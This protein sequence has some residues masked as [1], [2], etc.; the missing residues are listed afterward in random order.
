[1]MNLEATMDQAV[2]ESKTHSVALLY[3]CTGVYVVFFDLFFSSFQ[4]NF[5]PDCEVHY[6]IFTDAELPENIR[7]NKFVHIVPCKAQ[8]WPYPTLKRFEMFQVVEQELRSSFDFV[9]FINANFQCLRTVFGTDVLPRAEQG[10]RY[11]FVTHPGYYNKKPDYFPYE[12]N[13]KSNAYIP[14]G[15]G[16]TYICGGMNGGTS[17]AYCALIDELETRIRKDLSVGIIALWHDESHINRYFLEQSPEHCRLLSPSFCYPEGWEIPFEPAML[18]RDKSKVIN[19]A[20][21]KGTPNRFDIRALI[22]KIFK[23]VVSLFVMLRDKRQK[24]TLNET[25]H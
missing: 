3:I 19:V 23:R 17:Q 18:V 6:F 10:E 7:S 8:A 24:R 16:N 12:R 4:T 9:F 14:F 21:Y 15:C 22:R 20:Q 5:L 13:Q 2:V 25:Y 1:M 11:T